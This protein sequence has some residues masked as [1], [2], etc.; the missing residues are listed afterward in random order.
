M[1]IRNIRPWQLL[2]RAPDGTSRACTMLIPQRYT[3]MRVLESV[4]LLALL[5]MI[6]PMQ[7]FEFGTY[8]GETSL[9]LA[10]NHKHGRVLTLDLPDDQPTAPG[11]HNGDI[12]V[13]QRRHSKRG[14]LD[15]LE[16]LPNVTRLYGDSRYFDFTPYQGTMQLVI[17]DGGHAREILHNDSLNATGLLTPDRPG[18]I[19]W[20]DYTTPGY[21]VG[22][23]LRNTVAPEY[24][25]VH[26]E[27]TLSAYYF[28]GMDLD[29]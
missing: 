29:F 19:V 6:Q 9:I 8:L 15:L 4:I 13:S 10:L 16:D 3:G 25:L 1:K 20:H 12:A 2:D 17:V 28:Q 11:S 24:D 21:E 5:K 14:Y 7:S 27:E 23:Y 18:C 22:D 26:I